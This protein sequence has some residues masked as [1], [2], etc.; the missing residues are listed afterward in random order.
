[1][2]ACRA[3]QAPSVFQLRRRLHTVIA[4]CLRPFITHAES[5]HGLFFGYEECYGLW[6]G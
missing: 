3:S 2:E 5:N 1:M 6:G 4:F